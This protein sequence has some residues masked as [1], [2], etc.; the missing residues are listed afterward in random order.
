MSSIVSAAEIVV[1]VVYEVPVPTK[2]PT[3]AGVTAITPEI[4]ALIVV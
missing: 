4:G 3:F 1:R 2:S